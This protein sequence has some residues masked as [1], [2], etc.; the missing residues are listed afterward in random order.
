MIKVTGVLDTGF[1][2]DMF[3]CG[4]TQ[5]S[6]SLSSIYFCAP[7]S[8]Q[9]FEHQY[10]SSFGE[11]L[12]YLQQ[13]QDKTFFVRSMRTDPSEYMNAFFT[14]QKILHHFGYDIGEIFELQKMVNNKRVYY[15]HIVTTDYISFDEHSL[16]LY[17]FH[18]SLYVDI[19]INELNESSLIEA[20]ELLLK[21]FLESYA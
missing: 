5:R 20:E 8:K 17:L 9:V 16:L 7:E 2:Q 12:Q 10:A 14:A 15:A 18:P 1:S 13:K 21:K 3:Y 6:Y 19:K 4:S 11:P